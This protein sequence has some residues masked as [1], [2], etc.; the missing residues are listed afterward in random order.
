MQPSPSHNIINLTRRPAAQLPPTL[1]RRFDQP[2]A[3]SPAAHQLGNIPVPKSPLWRRGGH[4]PRYSTVISQPH[5]QS[6][7]TTKSVRSSRHRADHNLVPLPANARRPNIQPPTTRPQPKRWWRYVLKRST[8]RVL[9]RERWGW[10]AKLARG[11]TPAA[12]HVDAEDVRPR[13]AT[14]YRS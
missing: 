3:A 5:S 12:G 11:E 4:H 13:C 1:R 7:T 2:A 8:R 10:H 6:L 9:R 14:L